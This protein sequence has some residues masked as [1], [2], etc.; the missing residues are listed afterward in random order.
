MFAAN[1]A[2]ILGKSSRD[3]SSLVRYLLVSIHRVWK[4]VFVDR[5]IDEGALGEVLG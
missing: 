5:E 1:D 4:E 3:R 2:E